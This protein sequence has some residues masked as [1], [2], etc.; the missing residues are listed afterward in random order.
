MTKA[1]YDSGDSGG[2]DVLTTVD[3][4]YASDY[5]LLTGTA[6]GTAA[7]KTDGALTYNATTG[8]LA[9]TVFSGSGA[10]LTAVDA[11][12]GD[13]A[14]AFFDAGAIETNYGGTGIDLSAVTGVMGMNGGA[15]VDIDTAAELETYAGLGAFANEYLD[16]ADAATMIATL[17]LEPT[18]EKDIMNASVFPDVT[19]EARFDT[20]ENICANVTN[21][22]LK[23]LAL[24]LDDPSADC[25]WY[26]SFRIPPDY[27]DTPQIVIRGE[28]NN[29][30][31][32][33]A[34]GVTATPGIASNESI[35]QAYEAEDTANVDCT[36]YSDEDEF[37]VTLTLTPASAYA[38]GDSV[39]YYCYRDFSA[40]TQTGS[41]AVTG[42]YFRYE[43]R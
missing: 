26:G 41:V 32:T 12:T 21:A 13:S 35:D 7:P 36:A 8:T 30:D 4:T 34:F 28:L 3:S 27:S 18:Q 9:A 16:D 23:M 6:V 42:V 14:T 1:V 17:G 38:A 43:D 29:N 11:A 39:Y 20:L 2:V 10:S 5:V 37:V 19:G 22:A 25:G 31:G 15:Y 33:L 40:D 24:E